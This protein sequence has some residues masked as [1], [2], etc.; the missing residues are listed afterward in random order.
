MLK[1]QLKFAEKTQILLRISPL[2]ALLQQFAFGKSSLIASKSHKTA[3]NEKS[4][5]L[6]SKGMRKY[7]VIPQITRTQ[8][9]GSPH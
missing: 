3:I 5:C 9:C 4:Q 7:L 8:N 2:F 6:T 1:G